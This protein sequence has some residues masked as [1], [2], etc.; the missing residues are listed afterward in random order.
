MLI[1]K[2]SFVGFFFVDSHVQSFKLD[3]NDQD[4]VQRLWLIAP[5]G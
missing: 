4:T 5:N 3:Q 1:F 2:N